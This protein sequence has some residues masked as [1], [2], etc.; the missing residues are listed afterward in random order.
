MA[1]EKSSK[2]TGNDYAEKRGAWL[3]NFP[4]VYHAGIPDTL[5]V[6][7]GQFIAMEWKA[8]Q[9]RTTR[10]QRSTLAKIHKAGGRVCVPRSR[11]DVAAFL[12]GIDE[13]I[14]GILRDI[15]NLP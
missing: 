10:L 4:A 7:R 9:G 8:P 14:D 5:G 13:E 6:Y 1:S 12:D 2:K 15:R 11:A 3:V